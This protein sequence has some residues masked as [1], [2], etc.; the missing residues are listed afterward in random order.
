MRWK[1]LVCSLL[2]F[3]FLLFHKFE[4]PNSTSEIKAIMIIL[5]FFI[6]QSGPSSSSSWSVILSFLCVLLLGKLR[7]ERRAPISLACY[8][9]HRKKC[10]NKMWITLFSSS[11]VITSFPFWKSLFKLHTNLIKMMI[12]DQRITLQCFSFFLASLCFSL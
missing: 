7:S 1:K 2:P 11:S 10:W 8:L 6:N 4:M 5:P 9:L 3:D 12:V